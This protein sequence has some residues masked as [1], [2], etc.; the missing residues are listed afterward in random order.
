MSKK[1]ILISL[2]ESELKAVKEVVQTTLVEYIRYDQVYDGNCYKDERIQ[3]TCALN[4]IKNPIKFAP[5]EGEDH[6]EKQ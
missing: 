5:N 2:T 6:K 3:L 1:E 4:K